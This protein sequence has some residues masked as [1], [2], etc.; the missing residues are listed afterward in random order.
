VP[1]GNRVAALSLAAVAPSRCDCL[2]LI[3]LSAPNSSRSPWSSGS[4]G[5][6]SS[7]G[8]LH[9]DEHGT[10]LFE[11][12]EEAG[13][14]LGYGGLFKSWSPEQVSTVF[15]LIRPSNAQANG[16]H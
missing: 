16:V 9:G 12:A 8:N 3:A 5:W 14:R 11:D 7:Q 2:E 13:R 10:K 15:A 6:I 1:G 4:S